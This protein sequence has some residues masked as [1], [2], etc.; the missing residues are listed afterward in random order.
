M[1]AATPANVSDADIDGAYVYLLGRA[2]VVRQERMDT[3]AKGFAYN[4]IKYNPLGSADFVNPN[5][6]VAYLEAWVA[7]D[8]RSPVILEIP[9]IEGRYYTAQILD[10]WAEVIANI[11]ERTFPSKPYGKFA[12]VAPGSTAR[13]PPDATRIELHSDKAKV[14]GR[15]ELKGDPDGAL[16]LQRQFRLRSAG[17]PAIRPP[18]ALAMFENKALAGPEI[19]DH[20]EAILDSA[21]DVSPVA[22]SMQQKVRTVAAHVAA[23]KA[24]R[25]AVAD[26]LGSRVVPAFERFVFAEAGGYRNHWTVGNSA[27]NY[28]ADFRRRAAASYAGIWANAPSEAVY[29]AA[30]RDADEQTLN[31]SNAYVLQF[32]A[33]DL[34]DARVNAYWSVILVGVPDYRVVP[35]DLKRYNFNSYSKL[36]REP[37]GSLKIGFG[38]KPVDGVPESNWLPAP[39]GKPFSLTL[40]CYVPKNDVIAGEWA[41]PAIRK[42]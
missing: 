33:D 31:G 23:S 2:F 15:I 22:A 38:S 10:E 3:R 8:D 28:G 13:I 20:A 37:D 25:Q 32:P 1:L 26:L 17:K 16:A 30:T 27:G 35:N 14:L 40:R 7:V 36:A 39:E 21:L 34:P 9:K 6:D 42:I 29:F 11:N 5:F 12:L 19:F 41:P 24:N 18:P 4:R